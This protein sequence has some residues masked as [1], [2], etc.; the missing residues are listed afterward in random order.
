MFVFSNYSEFRYSDSGV[1]ILGSGKICRMLCRVGHYADTPF[2]LCL[3]V[4]WQGTSRV[5]RKTGRDAVFFAIVLCVVVIFRFYHL[6][7]KPLEMLNEAASNAYM[8]RH[9]VA[10]AKLLFQDHW[11]L[12]TPISWN[13][14]FVRM[15]CNLST[16]LL[17][18]LSQFCVS[19]EKCI[20]PT[21]HVPEGK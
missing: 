2:G 7:V 12:M 11:Q 5:D 17:V 21:H 4:R 9:Y 1:S 20:P 16:G 8:M 13:S 18:L 10:D 6:D 19:I 3:L 14:M 15:P